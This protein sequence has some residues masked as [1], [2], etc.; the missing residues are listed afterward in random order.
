MRKAWLMVVVWCL[1]ISWKNRS[2]SKKLNLNRFDFWFLDSFFGIFG[3]WVGLWVFQRCNWGVLGLKRL[4][5][6]VFGHKKCC[7]Y[8][9]ATTPCCLFWQTMYHLCLFK[10]IEA[11]EKKRVKPRHASRAPGLEGPREH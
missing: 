5:I 2:R 10:K 11:N 8:F 3:W 7:L 1:N 9:L 6:Q 4:K